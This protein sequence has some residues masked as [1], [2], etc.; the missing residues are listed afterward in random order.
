MFKHPA[1]GNIAFFQRIRVTP[2]WQNAF[3]IQRKCVYVFLNNK[4]IPVL[5][6]T[7]PRPVKMDAAAF[8]VVLV[9]IH[10]LRALLIKLLLKSC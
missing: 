3:T 7:T 8:V 6:K 1:S 2:S 10:N 5:I 4:L 9:V